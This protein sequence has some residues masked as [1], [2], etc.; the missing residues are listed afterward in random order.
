MAEKA[1][2][3]ELL[4]CCEMSIKE[5]AEKFSVAANT[6]STILSLYFGKPKKD[7]VKMS[8]V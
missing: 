3:I 5:V 6:I 4:V 1:E 8:K 7:V 2:I